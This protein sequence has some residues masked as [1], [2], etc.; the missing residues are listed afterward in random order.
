MARR[1]ISIN[2]DAFEIGN[3]L[4]GVEFPLFCYG[5]V[6]VCV[7]VS[8]CVCVFNRTRSTWTQRDQEMRS[9]R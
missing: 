8:V 7:C 1:I 3:E 4:W 5:G 9:I 6:C 2:P